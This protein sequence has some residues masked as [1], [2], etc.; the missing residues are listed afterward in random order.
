MNRRDALKLTE[1]LWHVAPSWSKHQTTEVQALWTGFFE[2]RLAT[3][4]RGFDAITTMLEQ[5]EFPS[6]PSLYKAMMGLPRLMP[7]AETEEVTSGRAEAEK[8][9]RGW[10][11]LE[12][13]ERDRYRLI[14]SG[15]RAMP[16]RDGFAWSVNEGLAR[17]LWWRDSHRTQQAAE[18]AKEKP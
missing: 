9:R 7:S 18:A 11:R 6:L 10:K 4:A 2:R 3:Y 12:E 15:V 16:E 1:Y 5:A 13:T 14:A 8:M 17:S